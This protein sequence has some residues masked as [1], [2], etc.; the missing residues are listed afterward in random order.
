MELLGKGLSRKQALLALG[1]FGVL[2]GSGAT[3]LLSSPART[4]AA[5]QLAALKMLMSRSPGE[6][7]VAN[8]TKTKDKT[9]RARRLPRGDGD[10]GDT[11]GAEDKNKRARV[12]PR[13]GDLQDI[14]ILDAV[15][16]ILPTGIGIPGETPALLE[17]VSNGGYLPGFG[18]LPGIGGGGGG[19]GLPINPTPP[20]GPVVTPPQ[21]PGISPVPEPSTWAMMMIGMLLTGGMLRFRNKRAM[22]SSKELCAIVSSS[23]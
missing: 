10:I 15:P 8:L 14:P 12:L 20:P 22:L 6:R 1:L 23:R 17:N 21:P 16:Q 18:G 3:M 11:P 4:V 7:T 9:T 2:A 13:S 5:D 19:G